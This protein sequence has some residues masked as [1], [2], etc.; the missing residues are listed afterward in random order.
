MRTA[1]GNAG[2]VAIK[3]APAVGSECRATLGSGSDNP[4]WFY[5]AAQSLLGK[6]AGQQLHLITGYPL[7][8]CYAYTA[9]NAEERRR[10][11]EHFLRRLFHK[12]QGEPF[13]NA[14]MDGCGWWRDRERVAS[15]GRQVIE[16]VN[17][18][19]FK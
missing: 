10:P 11:P 7:S 4:E 17:Q 16:S 9:R 8:S 15:I 3:V 18:G 6:D 2:R 12:P 1:S 5:E 19:G 14:F 13:L